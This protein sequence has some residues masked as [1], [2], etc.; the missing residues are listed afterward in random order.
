MEVSAAT[1]FSPS[2]PSPPSTTSK[3]L[4]AGL[5]AET[6]PHCLPLSLQHL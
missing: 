3:R 2:A 1:I 5:A 4:L 6:P